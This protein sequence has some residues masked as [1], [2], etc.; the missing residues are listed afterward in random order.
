M[1]TL[2]IKQTMPSIFLSMIL[3]LLASCATTGST[4]PHAFNALL[5][6]EYD[7]K[8]SK[9]I[10]VKDFS[11]EDTVVSNVYFQW[12]DVSSSSGEH[13]VEWRWYKE[14]ILVSQSEKRLKFNTSPYT[15]WTTRAASSL[16]VGHY[17]V[18]TILDGQVA[19]SSEF[20][21]KP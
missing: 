21:I 15:T 2:K 8:L 4:M 1:N 5:T 6:T 19:S 11:L 16:G 9:R 12:A 7:Q 3:L 17:K 14:G 20:D 18:D 13:R 10:P